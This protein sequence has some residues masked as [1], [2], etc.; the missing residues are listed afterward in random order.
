MECDEVT[1]QLGPYLDHELRSE[2]R[3]AVDTHLAVCPACRAEL[4]ALRAAVAQLEPDGSVA[5]PQALW[6]AIEERLDAAAPKSARRRWSGAKLAI[7]RR[8]MAA[9]A[10]VLFVVGLGWLGIAWFQGTV[11]Q[12][13]ASAIDFG[14]LL[15]ALPLNPQKAL[16]RFLTQY[17]AREIPADHARTQAPA[18]DFEVP[19]TLPGGFR[20]TAVYALRFGGAPGIAAEYAGP[21]DEFLAALFHPPVQRENFGTHRDYPCVIGQHRGHSV[22]VGPWR[23]VHLTDPTTCH[24][25][26]SKLDPQAELPAVMAAVAPRSVPWKTSEHGH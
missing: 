6:T 7:I 21:N 22:E 12:A 24:C 17:E 26:L 25:V 2:V 18:L 13:E 14:V 5:V 4:E 23:L 8:P 20:R 15:D 19:D 3:R 16:N 11:P 10:T 1:P 9:A